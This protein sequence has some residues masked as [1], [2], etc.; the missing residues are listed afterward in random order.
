MGYIKRCA[1][2]VLITVSTT[3]IAGD[4]ED[5][6]KYEN[7]GL[8]AKAALSFYSGARAGDARAIREL[9]RAYYDGRGVE[10]N[11]EASER[12]MHLAAER[13]DKE[14]QVLYGSM[15]LSHTGYTC[16]VDG[17]NADVGYSWF[18]IAGEDTIKKMGFDGED[19]ARA[20]NRDLEY[21]SAMLNIDAQL[22]AQKRADAWKAKHESPADAVASGVP[23]ST[24]PEL[25]TDEISQLDRL[26]DTTNIKARVKQ[27]EA[28]LAV[29][30]EQ[31]RH[32]NDLRSGRVRI[33]NIKDA[34]IA[35]GQISDLM[36][37]M[38]SPLL[39]PNH[40]IYGARI[41]L[42]A[43][44]RKGVVRARWD[45]DSVESILES[46]LQ[47]ASQETYA[48]GAKRISNIRVKYG[49][50]V[51]YAQLNQS[52]KT[53]VMSKNLRMG[54]AVWVIGRYVGNRK[55]R[56][57]NGTQGTMPVLEVLYLSE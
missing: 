40:A 49:G 42:D 18:L 1:L 19:M 37:L 45:L 47:E 43:E 29:K 21:E 35:Q 5:G 23:A 34:W 27:E 12:L 55:F 52:K 28:A 8:H 50:S 39:K 7:A 54:Q 4:Y 14:A 3:A 38:A 13:G 56:R 46:P 41:T 30:E 2:L 11:K 25:S 15:C 9:A 31:K 44:E 36:E 57:A 32:A 48:Q 53:I 22:A 10:Q 26:V 20:V 24:T 6:V 17:S 16:A 33:S 51:Y